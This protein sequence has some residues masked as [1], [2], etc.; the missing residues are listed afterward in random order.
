[1]IFVA[2]G[3]DD[4]ANALAVLDE[5]GDVGDNDVDAK[6]F[7]FGEHESGVDDDDV[8]SPADRHAVHAEFAEAP[9]GDDLQFSSGH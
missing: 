9:Q 6:Q 4:A 7:G 2:V 8:V 1:V 5:V 3:Q